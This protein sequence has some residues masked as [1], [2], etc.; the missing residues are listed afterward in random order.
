MREEKNRLGRRDFVRVTG[1]IALGST[2]TEVAARPEEVAGPGE[3]QPVPFRKLASLHLEMDH[4]RSMAIGV[5]GVI[6]VAGKNI[7]CVLSPDG[8]TCASHPL[9]GHPDALAL[10]DESTLLLGMRTELQALDLRDF[11]V[12]PW[13]C[14]E[15]EAWITSIASD[16]DNMY[17]ADAGNRIVLRFDKQ[18]ILL[19]RIGERNT[20]RDIPG[21]IV[22]SP[23]FDVALD[24]MGAL[25]VTNPGRHGLESYRPDGSLISSWYRP[26]MDA[27]GF[28]G[29]CNPTRI[30]FL[31]DHSLVTSEK[32]LNR[33][34]VLAPDHSVR[35]VLT[36]PE[37]GEGI[38]FDYYCREA[39]PI[40]DID[41]TP[42]DR[43]LLLDEQN[44][45]IHVYGAK[46]G[47]NA[48]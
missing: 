5:D 45:C 35:A 43:I 29:C 46:E 13:A 32:G 17:V 23:Y 42:N 31:G 24:P 21:L 37:S 47:G 14:L 19:N 44:R 12:K 18:G 15:G 9:E 41:V 6:Y 4:P 11:A 8:K 36:G 48:A 7:L 39:P 34:K 1:A 3:G 30:A 16:E 2:F 27:A 28:C 26:G 20:E 22:P 10:L 38:Q 25:W 33:V 40:R